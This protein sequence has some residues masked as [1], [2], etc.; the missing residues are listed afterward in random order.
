VGLNERALRYAVTLAKMQRNQVTL[1]ASTT[2][3]TYRA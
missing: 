1:R 3:Y 2:M